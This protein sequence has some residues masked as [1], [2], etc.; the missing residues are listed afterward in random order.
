MS[1]HTFLREVLATD[2]YRFRMALKPGNLEHYFQAADSEVMSIRRKLLTEEPEKY[3]AVL[4]GGHDAL[5]EAVTAAGLDLPTDLRQACLNL[6]MHWEP[7]FLLLDK[8]MILQAGCVCFPSSWALTEKIGLPIWEIHQPVPTLNQ[9][10]GASVNTFLERLKP[11]AFWTRSNWGLSRSNELNQHPSRNIPK[12]DETA[13]VDE[14]W[15]R[16]E[17]QGLMRLPKSNSILFLIKI[18]N[19]PLREV[20]QNAD[21]SER[22]RFALETVPDDIAT[23]KG[24]ARARQTLLKL[25]W[26]S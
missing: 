2:N 14:V 20:A 15:L 23:Y 24:I 18:I 1:D 16:V 13:Q 6:G 4:P 12:L 10:L 9:E 3:C 26:P 11:G 25:F 22:V 17:H 8:E 5:C 7:D 21:L 19:Y